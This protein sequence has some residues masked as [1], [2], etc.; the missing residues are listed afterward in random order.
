M[1]E[2]AATSL[3]ISL[4]S[5]LPFPFQL[6]QYADDTLIFASVKGASIRTLALVLNLF[7]K[8]SSLAINGD[9]SGFVPLNLPPQVVNFVQSTLGYTPT[10]LPIT[11]LGMPL[12]SCNP[13]KTS[14]MPLLDKIKKIL[15]GWKGRLLSR[16]G[17][18][19]LCKSVISAIPIYF[20]SCF[21]LPSWLTKSIDKIMRSFIW[22]SGND[23]KRGIALIN[24]NLIYTSK[25]YGGWG[26]PD[27]KLK[28]IAMLLRWWWH[29]YS[30]NASIWKSTA[31]LLFSRRDSTIPPLRWIKQ[32]SFFWRFMLSLRYIFQM[33]TCWQIG[34]A[35]KPLLWFDNWGIGNLFSL[36]DC[37]RNQLPEHCNLSLAQAIHDLQ[38][39]LPRP[40]TFFHST[41]LQSLHNIHLTNSPDVLHWKWDPGG[42]FTSKSAYTMMATAGKVKS[43]LLSVWNFKSTP[44]IQL[45]SFLWF[46]NR[47]LTQDRLLRW[48]CI[49]NIGCSL[50]DTQ[51]L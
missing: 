41:V 3:N 21:K 14:F 20:M 11:Y 42:N 22:S 35:V 9:K 24:W 49:D 19:Q 23:N 51:V 13:E 31:T 16:A 45:F 15:D 10:D 7:S 47:L 1:C 18:L 17:R 12:T 33:S 48:N 28:N 38:T 4:S 27:L 25:D 37:K 26:L 32:G 5:K 2:A 46:S 34:N 43:S 40:L 50:C 6:F 29:L 36:F 44:T 30:E 39:M 8:V